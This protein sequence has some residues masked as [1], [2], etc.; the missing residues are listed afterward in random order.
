MGIEEA[1]FGIILNLISGV[2]QKGIDYSSLNFFEKR[3]V[4][5]HIE[6]AVA[7]V[8]EPLLPFLTQEG[9]A[10]EQQQRLIHVCVEELRPLTQEPSRLFQ[11]SLNGQKLFEDLYA[12]RPLP[13]VIIEDGLQDVYTLLCPRIATLLC[14]IPAAVKDWET[15][16]WTENFRRFD[17]L[18]M[19][20]RDIFIR[21]D[22]L[23]QTDGFD[24]SLLSIVRKNLAQKIGFDLD[25]TGLGSDRP[26]SGKFEYFFVHPDIHVPLAEKARRPFR[27]L[28]RNQSCQY[29]GNT[30]RRAI[31]TGPAGAGKSTWVQWLQREVVESQGG[32][33]AIRVVLRSYTEENLPSIQNLVRETAGQ[34]F[35]ESLTAERI[36]QW[37][38]ACK[39]LFILD[40]FDEIR[41]DDRDHVCDWILELSGAA[42]DCPLLLT[43]RPL[44]TNHLER[45][46]QEWKTCTMQPFT[47]PQ[48]IDY[49]NRWY[50]HTELL[51]QSERDTDAQDLARSWQS[52]PTIGPLTGNPLLLSTLLM[53]HHLDGSL[54]NG[55]SQLYQRY[56]AGMLGLWDDRRKVTA[57]LALLPT[58]DK[59]WLLQDLALKLFFR[60]QDQLDEHEIITLLTDSLQTLSIEVAA[61]TV[62]KTLQ[63]RSGLIVGPG[64]YSFAHKSIAEYLV[65][66]A[67]FQGDKFDAKGNRIDRFYLFRNRGND[68]W[69]SV[70]FLWAGL[71]SKQEVEGFIEQCI[72][73]NDWSLAYGIL[74]DQYERFSPFIRKKLLL[75]VLPDECSLTKL[76]SFYGA[77]ASVLGGSLGGI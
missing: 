49:I 71:A 43:S 74:L 9:V 36:Q 39:I 51:P 52:D 7:A 38:E 4:Q 77:Y 58:K 75:Q 66:A 17:E 47:R 61:E 29:F 13:E 54:P 50:K 68:R 15:E 11:G 57:D 8:V 19:Q 33:I 65:S 45:L 69:N 24:D 28:N 76:N 70:I 72:E 21:L 44:T 34:H 22:A 31:V 73:S 12:H 46:G 56:I 42:Q 60:E 27:K 5:R 3:K 59:Y 62:L 63:E 30:S 41:P 35:A 64:V 48:V 2:L 37:I 23:S 20:L 16:A 55:R 1:A 10:E 40:G 25:I 14:K 53:V 6:D 67:I 26:L 32:K 18:T